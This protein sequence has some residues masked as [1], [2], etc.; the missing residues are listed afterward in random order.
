[1]KS[2]TSWRLLSNLNG[3]PVDLVAYPS[4]LAE[5]R[6]AGKYML[7]N[8]KLPNTLVIQGFSS[9][10][11]IAGADIKI[12]K[13]LANSQGIELVKM[14]RSGRG[15]PSPVGTIEYS[16]LKCFKKVQIT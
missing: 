6:I 9:K 11:I 15:A 1:M 13:E 16:E 5:G 8:D 12:D 3:K 2:N 10:G 4:A 7:S 14:P